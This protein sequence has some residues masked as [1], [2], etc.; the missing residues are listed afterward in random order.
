[1]KSKVIYVEGLQRDVEFYIGTTQYENF[2]VIDIGSDEDIW[3][4]AKDSS[5]CHVVCK[6][7]ENLNKKEVKYIVKVGALLCKS[8]TN[9]LKS[10]KNIDF[11]Y[12]MIKNI[13]KTDIA[14][15]VETKNTKIINL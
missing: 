4:H 8:N 14:G 3:I 5:S 12:T 6:V 7:P 15:C 9:K 11:I 13:K 2:D 1:M 10:L